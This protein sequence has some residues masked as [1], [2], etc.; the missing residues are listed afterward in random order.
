MFSPGQAIG[1]RFR[2]NLNKQTNNN[3]QTDDLI[4][5]H[6][7][8][9]QCLTHSLTAGPQNGSVSATDRPDVGTEV[10]K[11]VSLVSLWRSLEHKCGPLDLQPRVSGQSAF[12][13]ACA[14]QTTQIVTQII[15]SAS[16]TPW[17]HHHHHH[18]HRHRRR[19]RR[20]RHHHHHRR[21]RRHHHYHHQHHLSLNRQDRWGTADDFAT[22]F[23]HF[24]LFSTA[25]WDLESSHL[26]LCPPCL[27]PPFTVPCIVG[28]T[29]NRYDFHLDQLIV[30][31]ISTTKQT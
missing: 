9:H 2:C 3:H 8:C 11:G 4:R 31:R 25:L 30:L 29:H 12:R 26:F 16:G 24:F 27:L 6:C 28:Q 1:N 18:R 23:P 15:E 13:Q 21:R 20:R 14:R 19:R 7:L 5:G 22:S 17:N 10:G